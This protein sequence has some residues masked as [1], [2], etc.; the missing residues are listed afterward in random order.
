MANVLTLLGLSAAGSLA[1]QVWG[2]QRAVPRRGSALRRHS[3]LANDARRSGL[4]KIRHGN[5]RHDIEV[6]RLDALR[7]PNED[8]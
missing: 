6:C 1:A 2:G 3:Y 5:A 7:P 4:P 8:G